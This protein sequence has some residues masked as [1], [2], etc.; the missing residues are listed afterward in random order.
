MFD[1][2]ARALRLEADELRRA[3]S[4]GA[5]LFA[6][7]GSYTLVKTARDA[8]FLAHLPATTL[9]WVYLGV[10]LVTLATSAAWARFM[11][12]RPASDTL[13]WGA[14]VTAASLAAFA[15]AFRVDQDWIPVAFYV[16]V[17]VYGLILMAQFWT[18]TNTVSNPREAR[19]IFGLV[20]V[21]GILGGLAGGVLAAPLAL[22][23]GV[24]ALLLAAAALVVLVAPRAWR[25]RARELVA[26]REEGAPARAAG[27]PLRHRY[28]RWL[29]AAAACSVVATALLDLAFKIELQ[30]RFPQ[31][32]Q[33]AS[34]LGAFYTLVNL[35]S[36]GVQ[37]FVTRWALQSLGA[38]WSAAVLPTGLA[39]G[40]GLALVAPGFGAVLSARIWDQSM[41]QSLNKSATEL[42]FF[43]L[44]PAL[45]RR[46]K[47]FIEAGLERMGDALAGALALA[48][49]ALVGTSTQTVAAMVA[50]IVALW[51]AAWLGVRRGYVAELGRNLRRM[52]LAAQHEPV[53]LRDASVLR[54]T[55]RLLASPYERVVLH[56]V[57][58]LEENAPEALDPH[59]EELLGH[60][61]APVRARALAIA[62][63]RQLR[64]LR[65]RA[66]ALL[67]DAD[68]A[69]RVAALRAFVTLGDADPTAAI[70]GFLD[71]DDERL[72]AAAIGLVAEFAP[73]REAER[74][75]A[76]LE[77]AVAAGAPAERA[78]LAGA[79]GRR[80]GP[81][82]LHDLLGA[83]LKD[84]DLEVRRAALRSA[85]A[86]RRRTHI[87]RMLDALG[88][89]ATRAAAHAGLA[90]WGDTVTGTLADYLCDATVEPEL[91]HAIPRVLADIGTQEAAWALLRMR[92]RGDVRLWYR[93][94]KAL[95]RLRVSGAAI[96]FPRDRVTEDLEHD[97]RS[98]A[99]AFVHHRAC[100]GASPRAAE[101]LLC[102][103]LGERVD[104][105]LNRV[106]RR[107]ALLYDPA[108]ILAAY[109]GV[110]SGSA[111][112]RA[113]AVEYLENALAPDHRAL[114]LPAVEEA[115][116]EARL[117]YAEQR[118]GFAYASFDATLDAILEGEDQ[119][120]RACAL[121]V[122][123]ARRDRALM[124]RV[125]EALSSLD[126]RVRETANWA[127]LA[128]ATAGG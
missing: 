40:A 125:V 25:G 60:A 100:P 88:R 21:G 73:E 15:W 34:F 123:G 16:W 117:R 1:H 44:E 8:Q 68:A 17:N 54:E 35:A 119:W 82:R 45:R 113:A 64:A 126:P 101:R 62:A 74:A 120:L 31:P 95:N 114:V 124:P 94:L 39:L 66:E 127:T 32:A 50:A 77:R 57:D 110:V 97:L 19:R 29:A 52:N 41:R 14:L 38:G 56:G 6:L 79:L 72:R 83:L 112:R 47:A 48:V 84:P 61:A 43:P 65:P 10:G 49:G 33:M 87:P 7:T 69:V 92:D 108:E 128:I 2:I 71:A 116:D 36:L 23:F 55:A 37:L 80:A 63:G 85:G 89:R 81:S 76:R 103:A 96:T 12:R 86:A 22:R 24:P 102:T 98:W 51:V 67:A 26:R 3:L 9:P 104:Q 121:F 30:Q 118:F 111:R 58:L 59:V 28:V 75:W 4:L 107:L 106:F 109:Q 70:H 90:A 42:F 105:A 5:L 13:A 18:Y 115:G 11:Q 78:A 122:V 20:G 91:R 53:S 27:S 93:V 99:F 46:A